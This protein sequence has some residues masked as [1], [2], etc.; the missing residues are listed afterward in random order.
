MT[1]R[2]KCRQLKGRWVSAYCGA[3]GCWVC[4]HCGTRGRCRY[5][6]DEERS[7][8][9]SGRVRDLHIDVVQVELFSLILNVQCMGATRYWP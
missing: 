2:A 1:I 7:R 8:K 3:G 4:A 9:V 5:W 6:C